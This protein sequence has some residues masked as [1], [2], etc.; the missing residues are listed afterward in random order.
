MSKEP[1]KSIAEEK[2]DKKTSPKA[3]E[4]PSGTKDSIK[5]ATAIRRSVDNARR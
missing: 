2:S 1:K 4:R 3:E 5:K